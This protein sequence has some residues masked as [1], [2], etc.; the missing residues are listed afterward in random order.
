MSQGIL[1]PPDEFC[2]TTEERRFWKITNVLFR[3]SSGSFISI[4]T[5]VGTV[6]RDL[7]FSPGPSNFQKL[8]DLFRPWVVTTFSQHNI[9]LQENLGGRTSF[10]SDKRVEHLKN[11]FSFQFL[12]S[13]SIWRQQHR[14]SC[15]SHGQTRYVFRHSWNTRHPG[16]T[17]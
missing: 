5:M 4:I 17:V 8:W 9:H 7:Q 11:V 12:F 16:A 6:R 1:P 2:F 13:P 14:L 15:Y 3:I 10:V